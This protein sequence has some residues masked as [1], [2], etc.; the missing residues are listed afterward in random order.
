MQYP[1]LTVGSLAEQ[2]GLCATVRCHAT[3]RSPIGICP[4]SAYPIRNGVLLPSFYGGDRKTYLYDLAAYDAALVVT[5]APAAV[6]GTACTRLAAA[7]GQLG[8]PRLYL[9]RI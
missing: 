3:T 9:C 2:T 6:D 1:A 5:D 7:L 8:C 4:D